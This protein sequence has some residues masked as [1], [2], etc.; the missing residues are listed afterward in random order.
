[1]GGGGAQGYMWG[2]GTGVHVGGGHRGTCGGGG[3]G[4]H[5]GGGA[6]GYMWPLI[7]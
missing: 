3:T 5:V 6:Q 4:V 1:M 7:A 2:G